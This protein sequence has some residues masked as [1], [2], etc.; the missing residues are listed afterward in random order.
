[1]YGSYEERRVREWVKERERGTD[2]KEREGGK[3][4]GKGKRKK[5]RGKGGMVSGDFIPRGEISHHISQSA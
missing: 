2:R 1:V 4:K 3:G 5:E